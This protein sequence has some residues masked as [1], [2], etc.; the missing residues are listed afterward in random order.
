M[1]VAVMERLR[2]ALQ[3]AAR[4]HGTPNGFSGRE[5][6]MYY[7]GPPP[8]AAA[9]I[10]RD[11]LMGLALGGGLVARYVGRGDWRVDR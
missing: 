1:N 6:A 11:C 2:A 3:R 4:E 8:A 7:G 9:R 10:G 5:L